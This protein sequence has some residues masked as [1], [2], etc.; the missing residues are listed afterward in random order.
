MASILLAGCAGG[1]DFEEEE[2]DDEAGEPD[3]PTTTPTT[4]TAPPTSTTA[5]TTTTTSSTPPATPR[6]AA[7]PTPATT[8]TPRDIPR[9]T[10]GPTGDIDRDGIPDSLETTLA[11]NCTIAGRTC[12]QLA[13]EPPTIGTRDLIFAQIGRSGTEQNWRLPANVWTSAANELA[14]HAIR[15][16]VADLGLRDDIN[17]EATWDDTENAGRYWHLWVIYNDPATAIATDTSGSQTY[18]LITIAERENDL[19]MRASILHE[20]YHA[21][22]GE[23]RS[24]QSACTNDE[25]G[26]PTHSNDANSVL[27]TSPDCETNEGSIYE[28]NANETR[29]LAEDPFDVF[30]TM[31]APD[32]FENTAS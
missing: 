29:E 28:L 2:I 10:D 6:P 12:A 7:T 24:G 27:Y 31:N 22:L 3:T 19:E 14:D 13:I 32:W 16:Q 15:A 4:S 8:P 18:N 25:I 20:A 17:V 30:R 23:L 11:S 9:V 26:G 1:E 5:P 21:L